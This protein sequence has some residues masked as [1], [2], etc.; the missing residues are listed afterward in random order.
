MTLERD[1]DNPVFADERQ[2]K[3][4]ELVSV[5]GRARIGEL[6]AQF[7]V[8]EPT[9]RKDLR[10]LQSQGLLKRT[11]GGALALQPTV[12]REFSGREGTNADAKEAI[13]QACVRLMQ[14]GD[15]VFLDSGT[16]VS[17]IAG[18]LARNGGACGSRCSPRASAWPTTLADVPAI[19]CVLSA[20]SSGPST[21][22][23]WAPS[24]SRTSSG[25]PS[26]WPSSG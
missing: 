15:S 5:R 22:R 8:T 11:H 6:A 1:G 18:A 23:S 10:V 7:G 26:A 4:A 14:D 25:S 13:A 21:A 24:P 16:T 20:A 19:D 2:A 12:E 9:I 17:A 3:I